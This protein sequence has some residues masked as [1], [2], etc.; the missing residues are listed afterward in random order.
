MFPLA[1]IGLDPGTTSAYAIVGLDGKIIHSHAAKELPLAEIISQIIKICQPVIVA[2][3]KAK[4]PSFVEEFARKMG[5]V[6]VSP[7][8][9]LKKEIKRELLLPHG[10][11]YNGSHEHDCFAAAYL[12]YRQY[13]AKLLKINQFIITHRLQDR[14]QEFTKIAL[15]EDL[16]FVLIRDVLTKPEIEHAIMNEVVQENKITKKNFLSLYGQWSTLKA[17][18]EFLEKK[19]RQQQ[20]RIRS[21]QKANVRLHQQS[22]Q[23]ER[24]IAALF[25]FKEE[26]IKNLD[27]SLR[28]ENQDSRRLQQHLQSLY[29]FIPHTA[30]YQLLKKL[31]SLT[32]PIFRE[33]NKLL[34]VQPGDVLLVRD[35][36]TYSQ[37]VLDELSNK[38]IIITSPQK[39]SAVLK[40]KF[41]TAVLPEPFPQENEYFALTG[42]GLVEEKIKQ[43]DLIGKVVKEYRETRGKG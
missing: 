25:K 20:E 30:Q 35:T 38:D 4:V 1:I 3:D 2:T 5:T 21:L 37:Q 12:A 41:L 40:E 16:N 43:Q 8:E 42:K 6:I 32:L 34:Q 9:D 22:S 11:G 24:R 19:G 15:K 18:K 39:I 7:E 27:T 17:E 10:Y 29:S 31:P 33:R 36:A 26:R 23:V 14:R 13:H 28:R